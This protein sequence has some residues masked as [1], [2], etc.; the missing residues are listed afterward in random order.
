MYNS[1]NISSRWDLI[2]RGLFLVLPIYRPYRTVLIGM[3]DVVFVIFH[4]KQP[5]SLFSI[6]IVNVVFNYEGV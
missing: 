1:L 4:E 6:I 3:L 5:H 2:M